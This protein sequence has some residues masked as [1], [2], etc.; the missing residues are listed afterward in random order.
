MDIDVATSERDLRVT[1]STRVTC[2]IPAPGI[3]IDVEPV[4]RYR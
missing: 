3:R 4:A 2:S 1:N